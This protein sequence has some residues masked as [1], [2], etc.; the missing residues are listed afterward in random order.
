MMWRE[1]DYLVLGLTG[2]V[3]SAEKEQVVQWKGSWKLPSSTVI[4]QTRKLIVRETMTYQRA[5][6]WQSWD[7]MPCLLP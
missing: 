1:M 2:G 6:Q 3:R 7:Q 4:L 5:G